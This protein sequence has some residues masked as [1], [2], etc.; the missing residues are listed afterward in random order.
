[1]KRLWFILLILLWGCGTCRRQPEPP[2]R[3]QQTTISEDFSTDPSSRWTDDLSSV[4]W[5]S[6][7]EDVTPDGTGTIYYNNTTIDGS[8]GY[9]KFCIVGASSNENRFNGILFRYDATSDEGYVVRY[10][11]NAT[12]E[13]L[14]RYCTDVSC[15][16]IETVTSL[17][18]GTTICM[19]V[20]WSGTGSGT[21]VE[22]WAQGTDLGEDTSSWGTANHTF[23]TDPG[24]NA[25]DSGNYVGMYEGGGATTPD[26]DNFYAEDAADAAAPT[27]FRWGNL[28]VP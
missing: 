10:N 28:I 19:G 13:Y 3:I 16:T 8:E 5:N 21:E 15:S 4:T 17:F 6:G 9:A 23:T 22:F 1:M 12:G 27:S 20:H 14:W 26:W 24:A 18:N 2:V 25:R 11:N 7:T